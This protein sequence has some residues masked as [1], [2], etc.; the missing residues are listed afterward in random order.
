MSPRV[1]AQFLRLL[2]VMLVLAPE[3]RAE[4]TD[5]PKIVELRA[6]FD[7]RFKVGC[8]TPFEITLEGG[9]RSFTGHVELIVADCDGVP[10]RVQTPP[11]QP[12]SLEPGKRSTVTLFAKIGQLTSGATIGLRDTGDS[13]PTLRVATREFGPFAG[14][15][16][17]SARLIVTLGGPLASFEADHFDGRGVTVVDLPNAGALP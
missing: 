3:V 2:V 10:S 13:F 17:S 7:G 14:I 16:P 1:V 12:V 5:S 8:W 15:L 9:H 6:G 11:D 4:T